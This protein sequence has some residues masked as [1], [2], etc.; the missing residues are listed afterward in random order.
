MRRCDTGTKI[1]SWRLRRWRL[2]NGTSTLRPICPCDARKFGHSQLGRSGDEE[3]SD[4]FFE[5]LFGDSE[6]TRLGS[7]W[8]SGISSVFFGMLGLG[9]VLCLHFPAVLTLPEARAHYP[10]TIIRLLIQG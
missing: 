7:G 8:V 10:I 3:M 9:G 1:Q 5:R 2:R 6:P 4:A